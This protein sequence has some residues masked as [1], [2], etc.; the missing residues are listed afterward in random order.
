MCRSLPWPSW[1][2]FAANHGAFA[3]VCGNGGPFQLM[4]RCRQLFG[5]LIA[6]GPTM[7]R[8]QLPNGK[9]QLRSD[10]SFGVR[11]LSRFQ[12]PKLALLTGDVRRNLSR[13]EDP[14]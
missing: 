8:F 11:G 4:P 12:P 3:V 14:R 13:L 7:K 6:S 2:F 9:R 1:S 5:V 10:W